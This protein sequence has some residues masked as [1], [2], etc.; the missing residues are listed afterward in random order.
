ME[1]K[2]NKTQKKAWILRDFVIAGLLF[3]AI[4]A[5]FVIA[6]AGVEQEYPGSNLT[7]ESFSTNYDKL[8]DIADNVEIGRNISS[9]GSGF[10]FLGTFDVVFQS[11]FTVIQLV[12][13]TLGLFTDG[14]FQNMAEDFPILDSTVVRI[15]FIAGLA[16]ITAWLVFVVVSSI[17]RSKI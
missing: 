17:S 11:T 9:S 2:I 13:N 10:S 12:F 7:S 5:L 6:I 3:S 4:I 8:T 14:L 16:I 15:F 1:N